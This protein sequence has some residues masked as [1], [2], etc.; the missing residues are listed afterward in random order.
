MKMQA[1]LEDIKNIDSHKVY[2]YKKRL[3]LNINKK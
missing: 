3:N 2:P 1:H